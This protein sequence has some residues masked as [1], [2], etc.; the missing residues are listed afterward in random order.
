MQYMVKA[1]VFMGTFNSLDIPRGFDNTDDRTIP[2]GRRTDRADLRRSIVLAQAASMQLG[3]GG[4]NRFGKFHR[5]FVRHRHYFIGHPGGP[6]AP[7]AGKAGK[8]VDQVFQ[9]F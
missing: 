5:L 1:F 6:F 7:H 8:L 4:F 9:W 2:F 3:F